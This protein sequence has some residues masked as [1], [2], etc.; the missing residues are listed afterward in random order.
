[1]ETDPRH[2][3]PPLEQAGRLQ[4]LRTCCFLGFVFWH[5]MITFVLAVLLLPFDP[6]KA[7]P[8]D[9]VIKVWAR[10]IFWISGVRVVVEGRE[11]LTPKTPR[12]LVANHTSWYD[13][14]SLWC[15]FP[16][17]LRYILKKELSRV[18]FVGWYGLM[19]G[20]FL[21]DRSNP[22]AG[23]ET[24]KRAILRAERDGISPAVFPEGTRS[25]D[26]RLGPISP[27]AFQIAI[28]AK[29]DVQ[30]IA[31]LGSYAIWPRS[32]L[33]PRRAGTVTVRIGDAISI[34]GYKASA[35]RKRLAEDVKE[36]LI[37]LGV[38]P[39]VEAEAST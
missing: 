4:R 10:I 17:N 16:G 28:G 20:H 6:R 38:P 30:P 11:K 2:P 13:P 19:V 3:L 7:R 12:L 34:E 15:M 14:P 36:A 25:R 8:S 24:V 23:M 39:G 9:F 32:L 33:S 35:G 5:S 26:G 29:L 31:I 1:M 22:R 21:L 27:G 37:G 18:P